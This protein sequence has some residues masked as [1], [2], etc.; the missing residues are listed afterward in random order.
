MADSDTDAERQTDPR[1]DNW[2]I[3]R[4][5]TVEREP[6]LDEDPEPEDREVEWIGF[7]GGPHDTAGPY[8]YEPHGPAIYRGD[9]DEDEERILVREESREELESEES[10]GERLEE[11]GREHDWEWLSSFARKYLE[12][13]DREPE[14]ETAERGKPDRGGVVS[15]ED[16]APAGLVAEESEFGRRNVAEN[17]SKDLA[18]TG[19]HT[20]VDDDGRV[21]LVERQFDVFVEDGRA[22]VEVNEDFLV[23][24]G[25]RATERGGDAELVA[26]REREFELSIGEDDPNWTNWL[27]G[28]L[29]DWHEEHVE[30]P[31]S[32]R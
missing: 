18:F 29:L 19:S 3:E 5:G 22:R 4:E 26:E 2:P 11:I 32:E 7:L 23:G 14:P 25:A 24:T 21:H 10:L 8:L 1:Y 31:E 20:L 12:D 28:E 17:D 13:D 6:P 15:A 16:D 30:W 27:H 9:V